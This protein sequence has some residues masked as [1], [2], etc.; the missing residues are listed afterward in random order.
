[1]DVVKD[2][3]LTTGEAEAL[4]TDADNEDEW[5]PNGMI[6]TA[7]LVWRFFDVAESGLCIGF[8]FVA[9]FLPKMKTGGVIRCKSL[10]YCFNLPSMAIIKTHLH[11]RGVKDHDYPV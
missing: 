11:S 7:N 1:M 6:P 2:V 4:D 9:V 5:T 3:V 8:R 10:I